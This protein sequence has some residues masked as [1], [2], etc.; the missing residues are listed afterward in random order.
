MIIRC[1]ALLNGCLH[2]PNAP[3]TYLLSHAGRLQRIATASNLRQ[4]VSS[5]QSGHCLLHWLHFADPKLAQ[6]LRGNYRLNRNRKTFDVMDSLPATITHYYGLRIKIEQ[7]DLA[8]ATGNDLLQKCDRI[9]RYRA[10]IYSVCPSEQNKAQFN[11]ER[12]NLSKLINQLHN[13][14]T[15]KV[16]TRIKSIV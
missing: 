10:I 14:R 3:A 15:Q 9:L 7:R 1:A 11:Q 12:S 5:E 8:E 6:Y 13:K 16:S 4:E 2:I